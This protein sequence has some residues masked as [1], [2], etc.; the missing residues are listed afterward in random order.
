[1]VDRKKLLKKLGSQIALLRKEKGLTQTEL[2][3]QCNLDR[4]AMHRIESGKTNPTTVTL[5]NISDTLSIPIKKLFD[6][7]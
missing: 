1:M 6:F 2:A 5:A 4:Q 3:Y 7:E